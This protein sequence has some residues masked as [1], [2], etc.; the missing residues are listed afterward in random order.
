MKGSKRNKNPDQSTPK[1]VKKNP[2][3]EIM[4]T[5]WEDFFIRFLGDQK[6]Y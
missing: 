3:L 2:E 5:S 6:F 1:K 4:D